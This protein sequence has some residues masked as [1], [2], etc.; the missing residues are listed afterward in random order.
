MNVFCSFNLLP[1]STRQLRYN[2][3][4]ATLKVK[5]TTEALTVETIIRLY[6]INSHFSRVYKIY[7]VFCFSMSF[8]FGVLLYYC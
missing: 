7:L 3:G 2:L 1:A 5:V 6:N 8:I 4:Q